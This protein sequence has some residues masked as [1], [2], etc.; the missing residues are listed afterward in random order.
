MTRRVEKKRAMI[1]HKAGWARP[2]LA[3][4]GA[5]TCRDG[6]G[7]AGLNR[8]SDPDPVPPRPWLTVRDAVWYTL[9]TRSRK[10]SKWLPASGVLPPTGLSCVH[11]KARADGRAND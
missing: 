4:D 5:L 9:R 6:R 8:R 11:E 2:V 10:S 1:Q 7:R 3:V